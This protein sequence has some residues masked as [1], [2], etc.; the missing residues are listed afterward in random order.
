MYM[1]CNSLQ[2]KVVFVM[3]L[4]MLTVFLYFLHPYVAIIN[5]LNVCYTPIH[6][7]L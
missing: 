7:F 5:V 1:Y 4:L 6:Y 3:V 2:V